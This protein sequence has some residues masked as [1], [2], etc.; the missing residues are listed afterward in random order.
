MSNEEKALK[1]KEL[2]AAIKEGLKK[3]G[4]KYSNVEDIDDDEN[5]DLFLDDKKLQREKLLLKGLKSKFD[6]LLSVDDDKLVFSIGFHADYYTKWLVGSFI[7]LFE[8]IASEFVV[9]NC[10]K[11]VIFTKNQS[12]NELK[13]IPLNSTFL[14]EFASFK[15]SNDL[16]IVD[17]TSK[18]S[19]KELNFLSDNVAYALLEKGYKKGDIAGIL[20]NRNKNFIIYAIGAL[21]AGLVYMPLDPSY[22]NERLNTMI[23]ITK[24]RVLLCDE[25]LKDRLDFKG[26]VLFEFFAAQPAESKN[27]ASLENSKNSVILENS[28]NSKLPKISLNDGFCILFTS[29]TTGAPKGIEITHKNVA[30][31]C[32]WG[33]SENLHEISSKHANFASFGFDAHLFDFYFNLSNKNCVYIIDENLRLDLNELKK[34]FESE[35]ITSA[36]M[37]T[38]VAREF[39]LTNPKNLA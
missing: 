33:K 4:I 10:L 9:K 27:S 1:Q 31:L 16:A 17:S 3:S 30:S 14:D 28:K 19:Y 2:I 36:I 5:Y 11:D 21:K 13:E 32:A 26:E 37:T 22:P 15:N 39:A 25:S 24:C 38:Q 18:L 35:K 29:G 8:K 7:E 6:T 34:Y 20:T 23:D 12:F